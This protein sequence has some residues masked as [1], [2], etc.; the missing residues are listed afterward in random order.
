[1]TSSWSV[2]PPPSPP[3]VLLLLLVTPFN[4][5]QIASADGDRVP[6]RLRGGGGVLPYS[7][8]RLTPSPLLGK[9]QIAA[10]SPSLLF[11]G[12]DLRAAE[13]PTTNSLRREH[14]AA[15]IQDQTRAALTG[16]GTSVRAKASS[17][18]EPL[19]GS[20]LVSFEQRI[21]QKSINSSRMD[22]H[23]NLRPKCLDAGK[24]R[25][26]RTVGVTTK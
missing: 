2:R 18:S 22:A 21:N 12:P 7:G 23:Q 11:V 15:L 8:T 20:D 9:E 16:G 26:N 1:M 19:T 6:R 14:A 25:N 13:P 5:A 17:I 4:T 24:K 3:R 10:E